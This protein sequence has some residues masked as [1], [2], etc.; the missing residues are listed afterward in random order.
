MLLVFRAVLATEVTS[1]GGVVLG[2]SGN[3]TGELLKSLALG[4]GNK[5]SGENTKEHEEGEDLNNVVE[6]RRSVGSSG[7]T[8][9]ERTNEGLSD[10]GT[11]FAGGGRDTVRSR[12]VAG[13]E[14]F[15]RNNERGSI[16]AEVEEELSKDVDGEKTVRSNLVVGETHDAEENG[17]E[18]EA[19]ELNRLA[20]NG[21]NE[22]DS[23]PVSRDGTSADDDDVTNGSVAV[24][25][26][27]IAASRVTNGT[28]NDGVIE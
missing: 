16:G 8:D 18:D 10:D 11:N 7:T 1:S 13:R 25:L 23:D 22:R 14:A 17:K 3:L 21:V 20:T 12:S 19:H 6:P 15:T 26:V 4:L 2:G 27:N 28:E 24:D 5:E 9:T